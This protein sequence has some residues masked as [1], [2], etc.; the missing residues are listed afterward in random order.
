MTPELI[1]TFERRSRRTRER[2]EFNVKH[3]TV[4]Q[5]PCADIIRLREHFGVAVSDNI[6]LLPV[7]D[8][9]VFSD[10]GFLAYCRIEELWTVYNSTT[11]QELLEQSLQQPPVYH[12]DYQTLELIADEHHK[13][14]YDISSKKLVLK[15]EYSDVDSCTAYSHLWVRKGDQWGFVEKAT[16][17]E[18][19][20]Y[21][22]ESA[23]E[24]D[25][26]LFLRKDDTIL[27]I[28]SDGYADDM[29]LRRYVL[30]HNGRGKVYN[31]KYHDTV[32]F[33]VYGNVLY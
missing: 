11:G 12:G 18:T 20:F 22:I 25:G 19:L 33:D 9:V 1:P 4:S 10:N 15:A 31:A 32:Y 8:E 28:N 27:S 6:V 13:G 26:G 24:A 2:L 14:L 23:F 3:E 30:Q 21:G 17:K 29:L 7:F 16:G 5:G